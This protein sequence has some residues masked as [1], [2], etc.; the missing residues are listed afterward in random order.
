MVSS[1][2]R[3]A[4]RSNLPLFLVLAVCVVPLLA[5]YALYFF[6]TPARFVNYGELVQ[7]LPLAGV[8]LRQSGGTVFR[9]G[10]LRGRWV[11]LSVDSSRCD[12][13]CRRKLYYMRQI[14]LTQGADR[15]RI[16]RLWL[17]SD[18]V[19]PPRELSE[20]FRGT[21][22]VALASPDFLSRL[23]A[24]GAVEDH[25]Y[26]IDPFGNLMM[27]YPRD[28]EPSRMKNDVARLLRLSS[29]WIQAR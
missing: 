1:D 12:E 20:E 22:E 27:R 15:E 10:D 6:W 11:F 16:E 24:A 26:L 9:F 18:G 3:T 23:P 5:A 14:R 28:L 29:G 13:H 21:I 2:A 17:I 4:H 8:S 25:I 19:R 7:P